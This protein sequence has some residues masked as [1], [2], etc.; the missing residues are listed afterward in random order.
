MHID[1]DSLNVVVGGDSRGER[2]LIPYSIESNT[3]FNT[4]NI[5]V[6]AG[7]IVS[8]SYALDAYDTYNNVYIISAS[9]WQINDGANATGYLSQ[10]CFQKLTLRE[11]LIIY[12]KNI[13]ELFR[14][15]SSLIRLKMKYFLSKN[16]EKEDFFYDEEIITEFG[17]LGIE[18]TLKIDHEFLGTL[19]NSHNWYNDLNNNGVRWRIFKEAFNKLGEKDALIIF[20]QPPVSP[21]WK[22]KTRNTVIS[23]AEEEYSKKLDSLCSQY[24]NIVFYDFYNNDINSLG[25]IMYYDYQHLNRN[26]AEIFSELFSDI[27]NREIKA[28][29]HDNVYN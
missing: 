25:N 3:G 9:S 21:I 6:D 17:F 10:K 20:Y 27:I 2:Q 19:I 8:L 4:I 14:L 13:F 18:D 12:Q 22:E 26:G 29:T 28:R 7:E 24:E 16:S 15:E 1:S 23:R 11:K 5:C